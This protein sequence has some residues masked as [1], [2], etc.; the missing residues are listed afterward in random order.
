MILLDYTDII[1]SGDMLYNDLK[2]NWVEIK[3][4]SPLI[5]MKCENRIIKRK[6]KCTE[7]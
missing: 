6:K 2:E 7:K 4:P 1:K 5:G 3:Y